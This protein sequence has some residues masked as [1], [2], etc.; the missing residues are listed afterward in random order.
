MKNM[1]S[2]LQFFDRLTRHAL[3]P[4]ASFF[5]HAFRAKG[6]QI[7]QIAKIAHE[8]PEKT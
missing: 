5:V 6:K 4:Q 8:S 3:R 2:H 7:N 1:L